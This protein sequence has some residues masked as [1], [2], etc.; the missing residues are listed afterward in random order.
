MAKKAVASFGGAK[1]TAK[2][3]AVKCIRMVRSDNGAYSFQE[4]TVSAEG[5][6]DFFAKK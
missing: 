4:E 6:K 5:V 3:K 1:D 2:A